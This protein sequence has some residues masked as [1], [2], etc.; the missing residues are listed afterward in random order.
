MV[1]SFSSAICAYLRGRR[2][3][4]LVVSLPLLVL[5]YTGIFAGDDLLPARWA[6][7][8]GPWLLPVAGL[9]L[10]LAL[11]ARL[12][13]LVA[14]IVAGSLSHSLS[15]YAQYGRGAGQ[16]L[17]APQ[18][19]LRVISFNVCRHNRNWDA[20]LQAVVPQGADLYLFQELYDTAGFAAAVK[21]KARLR[22]YQMA[23]AGRSGLVILS[24]FPVR[25]VQ[26]LAFEIARF[27]IA[28][29][30]SLIPG[31]RLYVWN[32]HLTR[33][34]FSNAAQK[35]YI[36]FLLEDVMAQPGPKIV[37]GDFNLTPFNESFRQIAAHLREVHA[38][39]GRGFGMTYPA[40]AR[41]WGLALPLVRID[42]IFVSTH[43]RPLA[44]KRLPDHGGSDHFPV[45]TEI[46]WHSPIHRRRHRR[47]PDHLPR[48]Q[49]LWHFASR[50]GLV[51]GSLAPL[52]LKLQQG[53]PDPQPSSAFQA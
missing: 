48:G 33:A 1:Q 9:A 24:R 27:R 10:G 31:G 12:L 50:G 32:L 16:A 44:S 40:P 22:G 23:V 14:L 18:T 38:L 43:F 21:R 11:W 15:V 37:A 53:P 17:A 5:L 20:I 41:T 39:A 25:G 42:H 2:G 3:L 30:G 49:A 35:A 45:M 19:S 29:P 47:Q 28:V 51:R 6:Q 52:L 36:G 46:G 13:P 4:A 7:F 8:A 34:I 26:R